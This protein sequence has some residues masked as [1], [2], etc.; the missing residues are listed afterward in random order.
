MT[1]LRYW[2]IPFAILFRVSSERLVSSAV[3]AE[4]AMKSVVFSSTSLII[5][6]FVEDSGFDSVGVPDGINDSSFV[7]LGNLE[8]EFVGLTEF[9]GRKDGVKEISDVS[10]GY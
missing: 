5:D 7:L 8:G 3:L 10:D 6:G 4:N 1:C 9:D 2:P